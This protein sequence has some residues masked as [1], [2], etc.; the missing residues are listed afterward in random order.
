LMLVI[1]EGTGLGIIG[2]D[3]LYMGQPLTAALKAFTVSAKI[4]L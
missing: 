3:R 1:I 2:G 4:I